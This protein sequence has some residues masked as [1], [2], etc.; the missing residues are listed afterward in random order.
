MKPSSILLSR[1]PGV[2]LLA[3]LLALSASGAVHADNTPAKRRR[4]MSTVKRVVV[5]PPFFATDTLS[6]ADA[7]R[8]PEGQEK[9]PQNPSAS[10]AADA[11]LGEYATQLRKLTEHAAT[12]L[13][14]R[15]K[16]R[17]PFT[18]VSTTETADAL[19]ALELTPE[20]LFQ[21]GGRLRGDRYPL[22]DPEAV[23]RLAARL[24]ADVILLSALDEPR[25]INGHYFY[26]AIT[27]VDYRS[28][29][30]ESRAA[31]FLL[32]ADGAEALRYDVNAVHPLTHIGN[33]LYLLTDWTET[34]DLMFEDLLDEWT[35]YT[36]EK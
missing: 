24:H 16:T 2:L 34:Q 5:I 20:K 28:S 31:F 32:M 22:P 35:R 26:N 9:P 27:G 23:K 3:S 8:K 12:R 33:R 6:R 1:L 29:Q 10:T 14:E 30:V 13:P 4:L 7:A 21:N 17:T 15:V 25:H 36:P 11:R 18:V 19:K